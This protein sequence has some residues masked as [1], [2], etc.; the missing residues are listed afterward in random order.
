M[1]LKHFDN[2]LITVMS[3]L[4]L[5]CLYMLYG[6]K[7]VTFNS[8]KD[9]K[10]ASI[11]EQFKTVKRKRDFYQG[12]MDVRPGDELAQNDEIYTH[13][14][15]SANIKFT[16]GPEIKLFENS[17]LRIKPSK[18]GNTISLD[19]GNMIAKLTPKYP[20][21][22]IE[23][24]G[25]KYSFNSQNADIQVEKGISENKFLLL[26]GNVKLE[27][28]EI[29]PNQVA[30]IN[31]KTGILKIE[32]IPFIPKLP[33]NNQTYYYLKEA[34]INFSWI[35]TNQAVPVKII[36][37]SD[38]EFK[39]IISEEFLD[40]NNYKTTLSFAGIYFWKLISSDLTEGPI[41]SFSLIEETPPIFNSDQVNIQKGP[42]STP[43]V[44]LN[45]SQNNGHNYLINIVKPDGKSEEIKMPYSYYE[46]EP[47]DLGI[48]SL[49][50]KVADIGRPLA[51][52]STPIN[53]NVIEAL[54]I[55]ITNITPELI[56]KVNYHDQ[57]A[58]FLLSWIGP[59]D[60]TKYVVNLT[61][62]SEVIK[63]DTEQTSIPLSLKDSGI[64]NW[65]VTATGT[66]GIVSNK[67]FGKII[68]KT[69]LS[70]GKSP[71]EIAFLELDKPSQLI[72]FKWNKVDEIQ[73]YQFEIS[74]DPN[75]KEIIM[76]RNLE[77]NTFS[78]SLPKIGKYYWRVKNKKGST[79]EFSNPVSVEIKPAPPL[80]RPE[81]SPD[82]KIKLKY[83]DEKSSS[84]N[85]FDLFISRAHA[86]D[87]AFVAEWN[88]P[89]NIK[90]KSYTIE[91]YKDRDLNELLAS[92]ET[93]LPKV[94]WKNAI[95]G[96]F[97]WRFSY[98][99]FWGRR[100]EFSKSSMLSTEALELKP[101]ILDI[102]L[103]NPAHKAEVL[104][105]ETDQLQLSWKI[106]PEIKEYLVVVAR[107]LE[108]KNIIFKQT[109]IKNE[110][111]LNCKTFDNR[112]G[113]YYWKIT[114]GE[115]TSKRRQ[116]SVTCTPPPPMPVKVEE[117]KA[118][119]IIEEKAIVKDVQPNEH[120][121]TLGYSPHQIAYQNT[122]GQ[123]T[124]KVDGIALNSWYTSYQ[125]PMNLW[126]FQT[127]SPTLSISRGKVFE[128][129]TFMEIEINLKAKRK[130]SSFS[131]GP[132]LAYMKKNLYIESNLMIKDEVVISPLL[133][134]FIQ[135]DIDSL[136]MNA[137]IKMGTIFDIHTDIQYR[138]KNNFSM[139][140]FF[141]SSAVTKE[142]NK[143]SF[144]RYGLNL[145]YTF[146]F[147]GNDK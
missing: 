47:K 143:H 59:H 49:T 54:P 27:N 51:L 81:V 40:S 100:T 46:F 6:V 104:K 63:L 9:I 122:A 101:I 87:V 39:E 50:V 82:I 11:M 2:Y 117:Q 121:L 77:V 112:E 74:S 133:G 130:E 69:S 73:Q 118:E 21:L 33:E 12:W 134:I 62:D 80:D 44:Y 25:K 34:N 67:I 115:N 72:S 116:F 29:R 131:W 48:Y 142:N 106:I 79:S 3:V 97:Y 5:V 146:D 78:T 140:A 7:L 1:R 96:T 89:A 13:E 93:E 107:D 137:E 126:Y 36:I 30:I 31:N 15:S 109:T 26:N 68:I 22:D 135:K 147:L 66:S 38:A 76:T 20:N 60:G 64:Y 110:F 52:W 43:K 92:I 138:M 70:S 124:A 99:D 61:T 136:T 129:I 108:F 17:L 85:I 42:K 114:S 94:V 8:D 24:N 84:F 119:V 86:A 10:V 41:K 57:S 90:A 83:L 45:W 58:I 65:E 53:V 132:I 144:S 103:Q 120:F 32:E 55:N 139:G 127:F 95:A 16:N 28:Q 19:K 71:S 113:E 14:Q 56:E 37:A 75:F 105:E 102:E 111:I 125:R 23:L 141:D 91:I 98:V 128:N 123:Y 35:Y 4:A 18:N 145:N 88:L